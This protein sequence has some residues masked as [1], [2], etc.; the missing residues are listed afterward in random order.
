MEQ[1]ILRI[2]SS[3][4]EAIVT[5]GAIG[6]ALGLVRKIQIALGVKDDKDTHVPASPVR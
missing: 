5:G 3:A 2:A 1:L 6:G 4:V